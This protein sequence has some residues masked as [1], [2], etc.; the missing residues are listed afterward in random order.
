MHADEAM[1]GD[2]EREGWEEGDEWP[3]RRAFFTCQPH[4]IHGFR[5][6]DHT[7]KKLLVRHVRL[8][9]QKWG[10]WQDMVVGGAEKRILERLLTQTVNGSSE[11]MF[12]RERPARVF[13]TARGPAG[14]EAMDAV[15]I[16]TK[17]PVYRVLISAE[18]QAG[19]G[20]RILQQIAPLASRW[21]FVVVIEDLL[22]VCYS[23]GGP[24]ESANATLDSLLRFL[25]TFKGVVILSL[26]D[27]DVH[28]HPGIEER[29]CANL[30]FE[31]RD[32]TTDCRRILW[33]QYIKKCT[34]H[35]DREGDLSSEEEKYIDELATL[36]A[37]SWD[38]I[39]SLVDAVTRRVPFR[40]GDNIWDSV[41]EI[42]WDLLIELA[43]KKARR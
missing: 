6:R 21:R 38:A 30:R 35:K 37:L 23:Q 42:N 9:K 20:E 26:P 19:F 2:V 39:R 36:V 34:G 4:V 16:M 41:Y 24:P 15:S 28:M 25:D 18:T 17:G 13:M 31:F 7:W 3:T 40:P 11:T 29:V 43:K 32:K 8:V 1:Q 27:R 33:R 22:G 12:G 5:L 10:P 14:N